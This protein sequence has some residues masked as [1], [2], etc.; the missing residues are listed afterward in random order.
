[1]SAEHTGHQHIQAAK[2]PNKQ[3]LP[4]QGQLLAGKLQARG[5]CAGQNLKQLCR[6]LEQ[7]C[8][9]VEREEQQQGAKV[10]AGHTTHL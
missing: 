4:W 9:E 7:L 2:L 3:L 1:M 8:Y 5:K 6:N 10:A